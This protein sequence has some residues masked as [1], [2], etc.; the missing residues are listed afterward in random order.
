MERTFHILAFIITNIPRQLHRITYQ[1]IPTRMMDRSLNSRVELYQ[2]ES[3]SHAFAER[4]ELVVHGLDLDGI[5][6]DESRLSRTLVAHIFDTVDGRFLFVNDDSIDVST[7]DDGYCRFVLSFRGF[8]EIY[9]SA[10]D[11]WRMDGPQESKDTKV[12]VTYQG[13]FVA[14]WR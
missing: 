2:I 10:A 13:R 5:E 3:V 14:S 4:P 6:R 7:K 11:T 12:D 1:R 8:A 9:E